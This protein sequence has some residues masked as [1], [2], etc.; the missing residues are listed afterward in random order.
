MVDY[1]FR[2]LLLYFYAGGW[3]ADGLW[4]CLDAAGLL[5]VRGAA[6]GFFLCDD[7][8]PCDEEHHMSDCCAAGSRRNLA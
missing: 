6:A 7:R 2:C 4:V 1:Y 8:G 3:I 5:V